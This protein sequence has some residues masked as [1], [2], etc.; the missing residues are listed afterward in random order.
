[1]LL[2]PF[3]FLISK[4]PLPL[5]YEPPKVIQSAN[6]RFIIISTPPSKYPASGIIR[7]NKH[8]F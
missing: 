8:L 2:E 1:M 3:Q 7:D 6:A 4:Y 5:L